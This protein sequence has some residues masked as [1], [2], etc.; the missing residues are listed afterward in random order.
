MLDNLK[1]IAQSRDAL[2]MTD[3]T[4]LSTASVAK[5]RNRLSGIAASYC[6]V[7]NR[8]LKIAVKE[9][10][11]V[12]IEAASPGPTAIAF[13]DDPVS[14]AKVLKEFASEN[15]AFKIKAGIVFRRLLNKAEIIELAKIPPKP[16]LIAQLIGL[17]KGPMTSLVYVLK[18]Q[19][20]SLVF[21][22]AAVRDQKKQAEE[23]KPEGA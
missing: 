1:S 15:E 12:D 23:K 13:G 8:I 9:I 11:N 18:S 20:S 14:L 10:A 16:V 2:V 21:A 19:L 4:G 3:F 5:L 7:K 22:L 17:L 6:V